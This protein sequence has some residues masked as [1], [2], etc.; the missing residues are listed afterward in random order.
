[1]I[2]FLKLSLQEHTFIRDDYRECIYVTLLLLGKKNMK[3]GE[4]WLKPGVFHHARWMANIL[5]AA[6]MYAFSEYLG[7]DKNRFRNCIAFAYLQAYSM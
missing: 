5:Y 4:Q 7:Y 3:K 6:K 2:N 1:M